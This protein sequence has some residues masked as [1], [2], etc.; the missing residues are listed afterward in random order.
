[1]RVPRLAVW[2]NTPTHL[3]QGLFENHPEG[4]VA[5]RAGNRRPEVHRRSIRSF[6]RRSGGTVTRR[7]GMRC[8]IRASSSA[9]PTA[10]SRRFG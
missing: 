8:V 7:F 1:M 3:T 5:G 2:T 9:P 10:A 4:H 6:E